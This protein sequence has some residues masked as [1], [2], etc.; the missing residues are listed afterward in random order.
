MH[1]L[2][3]PVQHWLVSTSLW[4]QEHETEILHTRNQVQESARARFNR[5]LLAAVP[6]SIVGLKCFLLWDRDIQTGV[7]YAWGVKPCKVS[8]DLGP[9]R[10][11]AYIAI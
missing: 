9:R 10:E 2:V 6:I 8:T 3:G 1:G 11:T 4:A 7:A 5:Y